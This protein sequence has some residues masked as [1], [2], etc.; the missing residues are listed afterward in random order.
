M[1]NKAQSE[2]EAAALFVFIGAKLYTE[3]LGDQLLKDDKG[4]LLTGKDLYK[5]EYFKSIWKCDR[6]PFNSETCVP[7]IFAA[8]DSRSGA[9]NRV[10]N[11]TGEGAMS[12]SFVH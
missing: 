12:I 9:M 6:Q 2:R 10:A 5:R 3:C 11:A 8:G 1:E 7:G 4:F